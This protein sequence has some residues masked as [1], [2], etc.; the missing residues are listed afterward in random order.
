MSFE[1]SQIMFS[2]VV[3][4]ALA[5]NKLNRLGRGDH[6]KGLD[7]E[8]WNRE[9]CTVHIDVGRQVGKTHWAMNHLGRDTL[10]IVGNAHIKKEL[11]RQCQARDMRPSEYN[12]MSAGEFSEHTLPKY[13]R[14][15]GVTDGLRRYTRII[16]DEPIVAK[17]HCPNL[18]NHVYSAT[19]NE[20]IEQTYIIL[21][22]IG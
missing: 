18:M 17:P 3:D 19:S 9:M 16:V 6:Q 20:D 10:L 8:F 11:W 21:G 22:T 2:S 15:V 1:H 13:M 5:L 7:P 4:A 12:I 14:G